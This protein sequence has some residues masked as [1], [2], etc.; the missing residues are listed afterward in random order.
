VRAFVFY[1][2]LALFVASTVFVPVVVTTR[3]IFPTG[4]PTVL[5]VPAISP[6]P[7]AVTDVEP[8]S[9][10]LVLR[11]DT[12]NILPGTKLNPVKLNGFPAT[13]EELLA[14]I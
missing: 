7:E 14:C 5:R 6:V 2:I 12:V 10:P 11:A 8:R 1:T 9:I 4:N 3:K 13:T